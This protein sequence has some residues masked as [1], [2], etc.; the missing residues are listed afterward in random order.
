MHPITA[1]IYVHIVYVRCVK[2]TTCGRHA[3]SLVVYQS[4][5]V[6]LIHNAVGL[7]SSA[8]NVRFVYSFFSA[9]DLIAFWGRVKERLL[10]HIVGD[11]LSLRSESDTFRWVETLR[12]NSTSTQ[13]EQIPTRRRS[14]GRFL[15]CTSSL[16]ASHT[17]NCLLNC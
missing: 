11:V 14:V 4:Q 15:S 3:S 8:G 5:C 7:H 10:S 17:D 16:W 1:I 13:R 2:R 12:E 6:S 9:H